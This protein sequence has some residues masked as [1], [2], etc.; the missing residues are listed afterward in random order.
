MKNRNNTTIIM[1]KKITQLLSILLFVGLGM[2]AS[3]IPLTYLLGSGTR[4]T[5]FDAFAPAAGGLFPLPVALL[6][7]LLI[8]TAAIKTISA[9]A[10]IKL[11]TPLVAVF[12]FSKRNRLQILI[13]ILAIIAFN[14]HPV[15]RSVWYFSL[16][17]ITP[18][19][20]YFV[21]EKSIIAKSLG[22]TFSAHAVGGALWVYAVPLPKAVWISLIPIVIIERLTLA[23][24][25]TLFFLALVKIRSE[26][27][28]HTESPVIKNVGGRA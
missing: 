28:R 4:L 1:N 20:C 26:I 6:A 8:Q 21:K 24:G 25:A 23:V 15:G 18:V 5:A 27:A 16:F 3:H 12:Y 2:I 11:I 19:L 10:I 17:W 22:A 7:T 9:A 13:P 14:L